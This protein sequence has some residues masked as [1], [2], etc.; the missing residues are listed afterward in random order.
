MFDK[1][2]I[3]IGG[4]RLTSRS[5][6]PLGGKIQITEHG[7]AAAFGFASDAEESGPYWIADLINYADNRADWKDRIDQIKSMTGK[8]HQTLLNISHVGRKVQGPARDLAPSF[9]H[10]KSVAALDPGD[11]VKVLTRARDEELTVSQTAK[12]A[13]RLTRP[14]IV[15]GQAELKGKYRVILA[16]PPWTYDNAGSRA[17]GSL[18]PADDAYDGMTIEQI[19]ALPVES[20]AQKNAVLFLWSTN[21]HLL[22]NPGPRDVLERWGFVY[23]TN[24]VWDKVLGRPGHYSYVQHEILI[25]AVRGSCTPD[26][27]ILKHDHASIFQERRDGEHSHKPRF[28]RRLIEK[29]Y[30]TGAKL[31]LFA[32]EQTRGWTAYGNDARLWQSKAVGA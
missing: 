15:E 21:S 32:R 9:S 27:D 17:D 7:W 29:L 5:A 1:A 8:A 24:Y 2:P 28:A 16:D 14:R 6:V 13:K 11:Q 31:E 26:V 25:V 4:F 22:E 30:P 10:A 18:T 23:K 3:E 19:C 20:H 12:A